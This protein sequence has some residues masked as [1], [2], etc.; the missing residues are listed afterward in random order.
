MN[1]FISRTD[2]HV[3]L[4]MGESCREGGHD[5]P[6]MMNSRDKISRMERADVVAK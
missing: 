3:R 2:E 5:E 6:I 1:V 4:H